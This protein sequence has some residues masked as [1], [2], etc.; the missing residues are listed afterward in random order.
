MGHVCAWGWSTTGQPR[1]RAILSSEQGLTMELY[2]Q[3]RATHQEYT[4]HQCQY[5][6]ILHLS[7]GFSQGPVQSR[8]IGIIEKGPLMHASERSRGT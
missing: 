4:G 7:A 2:I 1:G 5:V 8:Y 3:H 6:G